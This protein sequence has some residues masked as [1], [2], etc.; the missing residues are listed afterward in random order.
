[1]VNGTIKGQT[2][3]NLAISKIMTRTGRNRYDLEN[4]AFEIIEGVAF[5]DSFRGNNAAKRNFCEA[6]HNYENPERRYLFLRRYSGSSDIRARLDIIYKK[7]YPE[8]KKDIDGM[9]R[10]FMEERTKPNPKRYNK[11]VMEETA[12]ELLNDKAMIDALEAWTRG[13]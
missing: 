4:S 10:Q 1:M 11:E 13:A 8:E 3:I 5:S 12:K 2:V 6:L 9:T 7:M